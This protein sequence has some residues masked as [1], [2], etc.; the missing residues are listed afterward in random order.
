MDGQAVED[1]ADEGQ[2]GCKAE[3]ILYFCIDLGQLELELPGE[4]GIE[5]YIAYEHECAEDG[6]PELTHAETEQHDA[7]EGEQNDDACE[8]A[9]CEWC[10]T[11]IA[12]GV[13]SLNGVIGETVER[14]YCFAP[15]EIL[16]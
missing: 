8:D 3:V 4:E 11:E 10:Q 15:F 9:E 1:D 16:R 6:E 13:V 5:A 12:E 2:Y 14:C 7:D